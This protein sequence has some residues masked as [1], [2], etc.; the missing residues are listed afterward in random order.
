MPQSP[1]PTDPISPLFLED[2]EPDGSPAHTPTRTF[3]GSRQIHPLQHLS[4]RQ[5]SPTVSTAQPPQEQPPAP[6]GEHGGRK[7]ERPLVAARHHNPTIPAA[8]SCSK[9]IS[10]IVSVPASVTA[11]N[12]EAISENTTAPVAA[13][14]SEAVLIRFP[15]TAAWLSG[16]LV[17]VIAHSLARGDSWKTGPLQEASGPHVIWLR[18]GARHKTQVA[19]WLVVPT[20]LIRDA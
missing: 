19:A 3:Y 9:A 6:R 1:S 20:T 5:I 2:T 7:R 11:H 10:N 18:P 15:I 4:D 12:I 17:G 16:V 14:N 8:V 13:P